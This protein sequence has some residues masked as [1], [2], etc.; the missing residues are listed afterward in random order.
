MMQLQVHVTTLLIYYFFFLNICYSSRR[1]GSATW[2]RA[3]GWS[4]VHALSAQNPLNR[5]KAM[6]K[7]SI[8]FS[9]RYEIQLSHRRGLLEYAL[10]LLCD[11][12]W[13]SEYCIYAEAV[14]RYV[15]SV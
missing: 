11:S 4:L 12:C 2:S 15:L 9:K 10:I 1:E 3:I 6:D 7:T 8:G 5:I 13:R 14:D